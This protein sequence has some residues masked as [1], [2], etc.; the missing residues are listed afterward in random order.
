LLNNFLDPGHSQVPHFGDA[1]SDNALFI[2]PSALPPASRSFGINSQ[3]YDTIDSVD[4]NYYDLYGWDSTNTIRSGLHPKQFFPFDL[5]YV[6]NSKMVSPKNPPPGW[7]S[8]TQSVKISMLR[9]AASVP[10]MVEKFSNFH[11]YTDP[12]VQAWCNANPSVYGNVAGAQHQDEIDSEGFNG[13]VQQAKAD[14]T[15]FAVVHNGGGNIIFADGHVEYHKWSE[16]QYDPS[17]L[18]WTN[19]SDANINP[20]G[21]KWCALGPTN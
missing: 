12:G 16:V 17:Q 21:I 11:E 9:P 2:C 20:A 10:L 15:R 6:W 7:D 14:W 18:P 4:N 13:N 1:S 5:C 19:N 3:S 8:D